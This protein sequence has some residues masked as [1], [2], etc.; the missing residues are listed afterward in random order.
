ML[1]R[2]FGMAN[3][4]FF[5]W[6]DAS[7]LVFATFAHPVTS[8][9][10]VMQV[11]P[12]FLLTF[13]SPYLPLLLL[14][15]AC[16]RPFV[17]E[18]RPA[19]EIVTPDVRVVLE[20][21]STL[22]Q[23]SASS[24]RAINRVELDGEAMRRDGALWEDT[25]ALRRGLNTFTVTAF[26]EAGV[27]GTDTASV[28]YLPMRF[29]P[30]AP[31][32][33]APRGGHAATLLADGSL[34]VTGGTR[35]VNGFAEADAYRLP[36]GARLFERLRGRLLTPRTGHAAPRL[37]DGRV[38]ILGGS[39]TDPVRRI[40]DLVE[41]VEVFD[42]ATGLFEPVPVEGP[43]IRR[44]FHTASVVETDRGVEVWLFGGRGDVRYGSTPFLGVRRD[45]R[46]FLFQDGRLVAIQPSP[47]GYRESP[48]SGHTQTPLGPGRFLI[49]GT[50]FMGDSYN[51]VSFTLDFAR[52]GASGF[53]G[54]APPFI[55]PRTRH[56]A[57]RAMPGIVVFFGGYEG[58]P[59]RLVEAPELYAETAGR[60]FR[61]AD[62]PPQAR[63]FGHSATNWSSERILLLGG[64]DRNG[65]GLSRGEY[66]VFDSAF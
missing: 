3:L 27:A 8:A 61:F 21:P 11:R 65:N 59:S 66:V 33:P 42:P 13:L 40:G 29:D 54:T 23:V 20:A 58:H 14:L 48:L 47:I 46:P 53:E 62:A 38:L 52:F 60:M 17:E 35:A 4:A 15:A 51:S 36:A 31:S 32:L 57:A 1:G 28:M 12:S 55:L 41:E 44:A 2:L 6:Y 7:L 64:F 16:E 50:D 37:P 34:L 30:D 10:L 25:L 9:P 5:G 49:A 24:F 26:D 45:L 56:A 43:P 22:V 19:I 39:R 18:R 63:R